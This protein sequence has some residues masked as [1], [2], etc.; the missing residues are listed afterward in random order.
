[1]KKL[2]CPGNKWE[3]E[4]YPTYTI[5]MKKKKKIPPPKKREREKERINVK[6]MYMPL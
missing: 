1:M 6:Q 2:R 5:T 4:N 3:R